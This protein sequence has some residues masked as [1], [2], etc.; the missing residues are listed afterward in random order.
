MADDKPILD[1]DLYGGKYTV[2]QTDKG[3]RTMP[4][5]N[6]AFHD[7]KQAIQNDPTCAENWRETL[8]QCATQEGVDPTVADQI[9]ARFMQHYFDIEW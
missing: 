2:Q 3:I 5:P 8:K 4:D 9:A 7:L 1:I 6:Q